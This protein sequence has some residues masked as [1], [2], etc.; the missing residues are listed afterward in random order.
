MPVVAGLVAA[1]PVVVAVV[2]PVV[3]LVFGPVVA[4]VVGLV[5]GPAAAAGP[6][7]VPPGRGCV[8][9]LVWQQRF[10][11]RHGKSLINLNKAGMGKTLSCTR[12]I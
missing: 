5:V 3:G 10:K 7:V 11:N 8:M 9:H 2:G 6:A 4:A 1:R 12:L